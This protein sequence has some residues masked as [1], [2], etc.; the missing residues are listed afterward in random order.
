M[1]IEKIGYIE[2]LKKSGENKEKKREELKH[3]V[4][5]ITEFNKKAEELNSPYRI[6][7]LY[8]YPCLTLNKSFLFFKHYEDINTLFYRKKDGYCY[9]KDCFVF[10]DGLDIKTF[11]EIEPILNDINIRFEVRLKDGKIPTKYK[12]IEELEK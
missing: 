12:I 7:I 10:Y 11:K 5:L 9:F 2:K 4:K 6:R 3:Y 1:T 8:N